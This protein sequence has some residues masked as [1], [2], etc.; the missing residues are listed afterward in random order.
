MKRSLFFCEAEARKADHLTD[1]I[2]T[3]AA[4]GGALAFGDPDG[5]QRWGVYVNNDQ[6]KRR[7]EA[8][9]KKS[10]SDIP[11]KE[12]LFIPG[13]EEFTVLLMD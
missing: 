7:C 4:D 2:E 9:R 3:Q 13:H 1:L 12:T 5:K 8:Y 6:T 11:S 10:N